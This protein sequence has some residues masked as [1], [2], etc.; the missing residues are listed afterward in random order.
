M[1]KF[2]VGRVF[3]FELF[4]F[5]FHEFLVTKN[6]RLANIYLAKNTQIKEFLLKGTPPTIETTDIFYR[7]FTP[8][9]NEF[10]MFG[11]YPAVVT[12]PDAETKRIILKNIYAHTFPKT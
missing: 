6:P 7:E 2:L 1:A 3:F 4:P 12:A 9:L 10:L 11:G 8:L 5:N